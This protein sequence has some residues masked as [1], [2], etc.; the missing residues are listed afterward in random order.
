M[1]IGSID[2]AINAGENV[3]LQETLLRVYTRITKDNLAAVNEKRKAGKLKPLIPN[4]KVDSEGSQPDTAFHYAIDL[5]FSSLFPGVTEVDPLVY[6][7]WAKGVS[8]D[9]KF[10]T[11]TAALFETGDPTEKEVNEA[12]QIALTTETV[13]KTSVVIVD[14]KILDVLSKLNSKVLRKKQK[15]VDGKMVDTDEMIPN[16]RVFTPDVML[17]YQNMSQFE[18]LRLAWMIRTCCGA[19]AY[20][21]WKGKQDTKFNK[22]LDQQKVA[23]A[24]AEEEKKAKERD[25][26]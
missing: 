9:S 11:V 13:R 14:Q 24:K 21:K 23:F 6:K 25:E 22:L 12:G 16:G 10:K 26:L 4:S 20:R 15:R 19:D 18:T 2:A 3:N 7:Y 1:T 17:Q 5:D 8:Y